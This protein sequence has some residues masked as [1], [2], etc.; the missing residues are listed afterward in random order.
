MK[1]TIIVQLLAF[2]LTLS[3]GILPNNT[4]FFPDQ[5]IPLAGATKLTVYFIDVGQADS[6]LVVCDGATLLIDG[7]NVGDSNLLYSFLD[8]HSISHLDYVVATHAHEDHVGGLSGA[9]NY[10]TVGT[11]YSPVQT[12]DSRAFSNFVNNVE[13]Q[14]ASITAPVAG[15]SFALGGAKVDILAPVKTYDEPNNTSIVLKITHDKVSF[16]FTGDAER[17]AEQDILAKG[18]DV[19]AT[20]LKVGHHGSETSSSY[21]FLREV[22]PE[23]AVI[24]CGTNNSYGHPHES[25]L[26]RLRDAGVKLYRTDMQGDITF[27]SNGTTIS[28]ATQRN[29]G[30][31]TNTSDD[32]T[33]S[34]TANDKSEAGTTVPTSLGNYVGNKNSLKFHDP[35]CRSLPIEKNR[36]YF[37]TRA[38]A[39]DAGYDPCAICRP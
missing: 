12:Y 10:A 28:V 25:I 7:G 23:Y 14:G 22:M 5:P 6:A 24:S 4:S 2:M 31:Q 3:S 8:K 1:T 35:S 17:E 29:A 39:L 27:V 30:V 37:D 11:V 19:S 38:K 18:Y 26:S 15:G 16:L 32:A 9:L 36:V 20:V 33:A 13:K 34:G 21:P